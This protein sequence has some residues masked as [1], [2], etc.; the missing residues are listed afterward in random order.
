[1]LGRSCYLYTEMEA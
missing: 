1:M